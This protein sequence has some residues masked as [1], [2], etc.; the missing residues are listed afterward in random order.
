MRWR[1]RLRDFL[2]K[3]APAIRLANPRRMLRMTYEDR[4]IRPISPPPRESS[5]LEARLKHQS[6]Q[7]E[8]LQ[9]L[10][11]RVEH[12]A[13]RLLGTGPSEAGEK[14]AAEP[15]DPGSTVARIE[16]VAG[17]IDFQTQ[18]AFEALLRLERL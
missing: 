4:G 6:S 7:L 5:L 18:R 10:A 15:R 14:G 11:S 8:K 16:S 3:V 9:E 13:D 2:P 12:L 17:M 1:D